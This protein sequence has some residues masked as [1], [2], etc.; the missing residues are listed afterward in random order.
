MRMPARK[1]SG[2]QQSYAQSELKGTET[3]IFPPVAERLEHN[4]HEAGGQATTGTYGH[5]VPGAFWGRHCAEKLRSIVSEPVHTWESTF[6]HRDPRG[7]FS[8]SVDDFKMSGPDTNIIKAWSLIRVVIAVAKPTPLG[9][10]SDGDRASADVDV[11][12]AAPA[13]AKPGLP[14]AGVLGICGEMHR[15]MEQCVER[16]VESANMSRSKL[17][18]GTAPSL[19]VRNL[20]DEG[21]EHPGTAIAAISCMLRS[22]PGSF[23]LQPLTS[24]VRKV[25]RWARAC[26]T[27]ES[28]DQPLPPQPPFS[29]PDF[30]V[31]T[32]SCVWGELSLQAD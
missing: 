27:Y 16:H 4:V 19:E 22:Y 15:F 29:G 5:L 11:R 26:E 6:T 20:S 1:G 24:L 28:R 31:C 3:W 7:I 25:S 21:L 17:K 32:N 9:K 18:A 2:A 10:C 13:V 23:F 30:L 14:G 12:E 8:V